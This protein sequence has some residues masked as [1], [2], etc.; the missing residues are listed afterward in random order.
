MNLGKA[1]DVVAGKVTGVLA[2][3]GIR[4]RV[5][6]RIGPLRTDDGFAF[7]I[8]AVAQIHI[9]GQISCHAFSPV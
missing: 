4:G 8:H 9:A 6:R 7:V 5:H 2:A 1:P 3:L